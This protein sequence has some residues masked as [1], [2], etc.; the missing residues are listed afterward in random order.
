MHFQPCI[1]TRTK[2][3]DGK[4]EANRATRT[5]GHR[6]EALS[7]RVY[8]RHAADFPSCAARSSCLGGAGLTLMQADICR[9]DLL[10]EVESLAHGAVLR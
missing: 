10:V 5:S 3:G 8:V 2:Y 6:A 4:D 7:H 1:R 9:Q